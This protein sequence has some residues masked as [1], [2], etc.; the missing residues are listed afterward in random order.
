MSPTKVPKELRRWFER[1][2]KTL[3]YPR[4]KILKKI[5]TFLVLA[6]PLAILLVL[7]RVLAPSISD[8]ENLTIF[9]NSAFVI[10]FVLMALT[11]PFWH[12]TLLPFQPTNIQILEED[13]SA[14]TQ[15]QYHQVVQV[16]PSEIPAEIDPSS[17]KNPLKKKAVFLVETE[18]SGHKLS[19]HEHSTQWFY[20]FPKDREMTLKKGH[21]L[22]SIPG[23]HSKDHYALNLEYCKL[24]RE[25]SKTELHVL[26]E[27][28][29]VSKEHLP[30]L[31]KSYDS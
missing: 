16:T 6:L 17:L 1:E 5:A 25:K 3:A 2:E 19:K 11:L 31:I 24:V 7:L 4:K 8:N 28:C 13:L 18:L 15:P 26:P 14:T 10:I 22:A 23:A 27:S 30:N 21:L 12:R 20:F 9:T 29:L